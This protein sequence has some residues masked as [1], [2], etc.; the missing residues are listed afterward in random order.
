M[1]CIKKCLKLYLDGWNIDFWDVFLKVECYKQR[2]NAL[3]DRWHEFI[4]I[5]HIY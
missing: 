4:G 1:I 2:F 3:H 5:D